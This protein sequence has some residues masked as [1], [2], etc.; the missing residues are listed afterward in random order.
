MQ[1][2]L[3][4]GAR[5]NQKQANGNTALHLAVKAGHEKVVRL[6][7]KNK[8]NINLRSTE[9][10]TALQLA[11]IYQRLE[12]ASMLREAGGS[13]GMRKMLSDIVSHDEIWSRLNS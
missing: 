5:I 13:E 4:E 6:L 1:L 12:V 8:A 7:L 9:G 3:E 10:H 2:L 11:I